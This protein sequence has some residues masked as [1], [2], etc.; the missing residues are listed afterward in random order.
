MF[1]PDHELTFAEAS[2]LLDRV[3][4]EAAAWWCCVGD[5][6]AP[7]A[8]CKGNAGVDSNAARPGFGRKREE[9]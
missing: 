5:R 1:A 3:F 2:L 7:A 8:G 4:L 9:V 6:L